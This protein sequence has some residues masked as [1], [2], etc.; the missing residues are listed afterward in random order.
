MMK[1]WLNIILVFALGYMFNDVINSI[2]HELV[3]DAQAE[4]AGMDH[5][6]LIR[7]RDFK[8]AVR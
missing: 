4:V 8:K 7:D 5:K 1:K 2:G 6:D 3:N